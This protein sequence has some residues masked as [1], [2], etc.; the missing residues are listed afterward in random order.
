M[1]SIIAL[2]AAHIATSCPFT[3]DLNSS[4]LPQGALPPLAPEDPDLPAPKVYP[5]VLQGHL[6]N[7]RQFHD[8][9][10]LTRVGDFYEMYF[11][12]VDEFAHLVNL[13][14]AKRATVLGDVPM[15]GIPVSQLDRYLKMFVIDLG[16]KVAISEQVALS[17]SERAKRQ[18]AAMY[19]R[20]VTRVITAGTLI[21]EN[22]VD[23]YENN[24]LLAIHFQEVPLLNESSSWEDARQK[25]II[26]G[27]SWLDLSSGTFFTQASDLASL[28][29]LVARLG[30]KEII[31]PSLIQ[32]IEYS[33]L[34]IIL[35]EGGYAVD[36]HPMQQVQTS[37]SAWTSMLERPISENE[38][39]KFNEVE[40]AAGS[41]ALDYVRNKLFD[42]NIKL[43]P[44]IR[45]SDHEYMEID[46][47]S[48]RGLE[49]RQTLRDNNFQGSLIH[50]VRRTVTKGG[51]RLLS[52]R[53]VSP[54]LSL[55]VINNRLDLVQEL[56]LCDGLREDMIALLRRTA[57]IV[58]LVQKFSMGKGDADELLAL[59]KTIEIM[60]QMATVLH[61]H[62]ITKQQKSDEIDQ[63]QI[64]GLGFLWDI[65]KRLDLAGPIKVAKT[66]QSS[67]DE[68]G[69][70]RR[71]AVED[72]E[73][74]NAEEMAQDV[75]AADAAGS[76][77]PRL[78]RRAT[79]SKSTKDIDNGPEEIWIMRRTSSPT[80]ERA[81]GEFSTLIADRQALT[82]Q[83]RDDLKTESLTLKWSATLGHFCHVKNKGTKTTLS[84][85]SDGHTP[86]LI[87]ST[88]TTRSFYLSSWTHLGVRLDAA[89]LRIRAE[90]DRV[91]TMLR[92]YVVENL[93][94]LRRNAAVL[95]ELDVACSSAT[96]AKTQ[97]LV[98]PHLNNSTAHHIIGG[99][100]PTVDI[101]LHSQGRAFTSNDC[102]VGTSITTP[103]TLVSTST[104]PNTP[105]EHGSIYL[106]TGP[107]M[108]GKST[109]LRQNALLTLLA[110]AGMY[111][112]AT[113]AHIGLVDALHTR[114]GS[115]DSL[116]ANESTFMTEMLETARILRTA[117]PRSF[118]IMDEVG[119]GT[120]PEDGLA[121]AYAALWYL[122]DVCKARVL[123]ATHFHA[124][125]DLSV[126]LS[127]VERFCTDVSEDVVQQ[128]GGLSPDTDDEAEAEITWRYDHKLRPGVNRRS[129]A[130][131]VARLAGV[132]EEA[133]SMAKRMARKASQGDIK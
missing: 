115:S 55:S 21:D 10:V 108:A 33:Q 75:E 124:L 17:E 131:K 120:T 73:R 34:K 49:I 59:A 106:I 28:P 98:R 113:Y 51:A 68:E 111:V 27:L 60:K 91:F 30:P 47:Q 133:I 132:P 16:Q 22:F 128:K 11:D 81:H 25:N 19:D 5:P 74:A 77:V 95:D 84:P 41:L 69:L 121:V 63:T 53:L 9:V 46:K 127:G 123:F 4:S 3:A 109:Y 24:Y 87:G 18:G 14:K 130:L 101:S 112:P 122:H 37:V 50:A 64:S 43:Q 35:G 45:R 71:H 66:I 99:R 29:S 8:C 72:E 31:L 15:A 76:Q 2:I 93:M 83:L 78:V 110:Q 7:V 96:L 70:S 125:A 90:E 42:T 80:L 89:K 104:A 67:I 58:R 107:N 88:K 32:S 86:R 40:I 26:V 57:D 116:Y 65:L 114:I 102:S 79:R 94:V 48:L 6:D 100:H 118:V 82:R 85:L 92:A 23:A 38:K 44:P 39:D 12:Q 129:H 54:S 1:A 56:V 119:R 103:K 126:G 36:F 105:P 117:T 13:K 97:N 62:I 52:Q 20:K 61:D